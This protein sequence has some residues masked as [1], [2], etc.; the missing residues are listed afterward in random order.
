[1]PAKNRVTSGKARWEA[2]K[3]PINEKINQKSDEKVSAVITGK[4]IFFG[5]FISSMYAST[6]LR[7]ANPKIIMSE[8]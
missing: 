3:N 4:E 6:A 8:A 5:G 7:I 2:K 1:M